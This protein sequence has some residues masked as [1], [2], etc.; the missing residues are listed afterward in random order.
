[1][2]GALARGIAAS[3]VID[4]S[5]IVLYDKDGALAAQ[6]ASSIGASATEGA[7]EAVAGA[8]IVLIAVKPGIVPIAVAEIAPSIDSSKLVVSIAAGVP[9][10]KIESLLPA[11]VPVVRVMPNT[12]ALVGE[13]ASALAA[14]SSATQEHLDIVK[15]ML[16]AVG[17]AVVVDEKLIDAVTG[18]SGSGPAYVYLMI[19]AL[20][21][22]G[23][24]AG[25]PRAVA[26]ELA[27]QTVLGSA[28][29]VLETGEHP[30]KLK[31]DVTTP[32]G[33][34]IAGLAELER[35][36]VRIALIEAVEAAAKRSRELG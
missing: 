31:D 13:G 18:L 35:G 26:V 16:G 17:K 23:V 2:G 8:D 15:A 34:T 28:K 11:G 4:A 27:A 21:D 30:A 5:R 19:E 20:S 22:G 3:G 25:L 7:A 36:G 6:T 10:A 12:P 9:S 1:M 14:G 29:M 33:T 32:G 24:K